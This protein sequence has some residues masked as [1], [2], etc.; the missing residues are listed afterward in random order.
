MLLTSLLRIG[1]TR[2]MAP[3]V[4][5][6]RFDEDL[7][8][9]DLDELGLYVHIPFCRSLCSFCPYSKQTYDRQ[10]AKA[11]KAALLAE[12]DLV[13]GG[14]PG[15][16]SVTSLYFG[17]GTPALVIGELADLIH[18]LERYFR[19]RGGIGVELHP[20]DI[21]VE[22]LA[23]LRAAGV[24]MLSLGIQTFDRGCLE[25]LG[26]S[27]EPLADK[28]RLAADAGFAVID[29]DLIFAIPGQT[30]ATLA[31]DIDLAFASGAT[32]VSTYP[33]LTS[34]SPTMPGSPCQMPSRPRCS[35]G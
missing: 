23:K 31:R 10:T 7:S 17:G 25:K 15:K 24:T 14:L 29:V 35:R 13:G 3:F 18:H 12:I 21:T 16:K 11:Y 8:I 9:A 32:Q 33:S 19:I 20:S 22:N 28:V 34:P 27:W 30:P 26:R 1:L 4:F 5:T 6:N 2:S